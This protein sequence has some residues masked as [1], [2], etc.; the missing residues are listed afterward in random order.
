MPIN[1]TLVAAVSWAMIQSAV[2]QDGRPASADWPQFRGPN[3]A[4]FADDAA[5]PV[6]WDGPSGDGIAWKTPIAGLAHSSPIVWGERL[7]VT[8]AVAAGMDA[9]LRVGLYGDGDSAAD[10]VE[11]AWKVICLDKRDG[12]VLWERTAVTGVP[13]FKRHTK[14]THANSTPCT[15]GNIVVACFGT[16]GL[17]AFALDGDPRWSVDLGP[18]DVGPWDD[19]KLQWGFAG[20]PIIHAGVVYLQCDVKGRG[21]LVAIDAASGRELW[22][23]ARSDVPG[24]CTPA[25]LAPPAAD[26]GIAAATQVIVNGCNHMGGYDARSGA[27]IWRMANGGGIPVPTPVIADGLIFLTSNHRPRNNDGIPQPIFAVRAAARGDLTFSKDAPQDAPPNAH[28]AWF[29]DKRGNYMQTPLAY[30]GLLYT[31]KDNGAAACYDLRTG[32]EKWRERLG[33][34]HSGFSASP[35][36]ADGRIYWTGEDGDVYIVAAGPQFNLIAMNALGEICMASPAVSAGRLYFR[37]QRH[38]IAVGRP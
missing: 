2:A 11:H 22:R 35:V 27:E 25:I 15:D 6:D 8:T 32:A 1:R 33:R 24:W 12:R 28:V 3:A 16:E 10:M 7:F 23:A 34:G 4:G 30:R 38:V 19:E 5:A 17:H 9:P 37:T 13:K 14:A 18:L 21:F 20:S 29:R 26:E 31:C 36:A